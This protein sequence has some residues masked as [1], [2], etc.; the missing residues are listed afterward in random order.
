LRCRSISRQRF[1]QAAKI[2]AEQIVEPVH[3]G[4]LNGGAPGSGWIELQRLIA[5][6]QQLL[7]IAQLKRLQHQRI[8]E[9]RADL[10]LALPRVA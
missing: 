2:T 7:H 4:I 10:G 1:Q 8:A 3:H 5:I 6:G 9:H